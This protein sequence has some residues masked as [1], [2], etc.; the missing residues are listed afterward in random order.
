MVFLFTD[1]ILTGYNDAFIINNETK[2]RLIN[3][4]SKSTELIKP[5][6]RGRDIQRYQVNWD[7][8]GLWLI[9]TFHSLKLDMD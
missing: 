6:L 1:G 3:E 2:E 8:T 5:V 4:D 9:A 7:K